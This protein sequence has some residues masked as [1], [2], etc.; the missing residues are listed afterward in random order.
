MGK[1]VKLMA[2]LVFASSCL[3][4]FCIAVMC[5][6]L[7]TGDFLG[8]KPYLM[9]ELE[10]NQE[11]KSINK[12]EIPEGEEFTQ[13]FV[14]ELKK[15]KERLK[16]WETVLKDRERTIEILGESLKQSQTLVKKNEEEIRKLLN[17]IDKTE[18]ENVKRISD[19][20]SDMEVNKLS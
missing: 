6:T 15:E 7:M 18:I 11:P 9:A 13:N 2:F 14:L 16:E 3:S 8:L 19:V 12:N 17:T 5:I 10:Y 20:I 1:P 4:A